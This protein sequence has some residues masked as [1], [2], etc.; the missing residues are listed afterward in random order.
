VAYPLRQFDTCRVLRN[1][2][3][4]WGIRWPNL[5]CIDSPVPKNTGILKFKKDH[6]SL[7]TLP[8][9][10]L[11]IIWLALIANFLSICVANTK[12]LAS[13]IPKMKRVYRKRSPFWGKLWGVGVNMIWL[14]TKFDR[15]ITSIYTI[16]WSL[17]NIRQSYSDDIAD[18]ICKSR[19][20]ALV[21]LIRSVK[22]GV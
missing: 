10:D 7:T 13:C 22:S 9:G 17:P 2:F 8:L 15:D 21:P 18:N 11:I 3:F 1:I 4:S 5:K 16:S 14:I 19:R 20:R 6:V 12:S